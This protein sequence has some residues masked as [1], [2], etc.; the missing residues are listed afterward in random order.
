MTPP[1][2]G[3]RSAGG[4]TPDGLTPAGLWSRTFVVLCLLGFCSG[5]ATAPYQSL[6]PVYVEADLGRLPLFTA[7]LRSLTLILGGIFAIVGGRLADV[8]GLKTTLLL[9]LAGAGLTGL[10][11]HAHHIVPLTMLILVI[12]AAAGPWSTAGQSYLIASAGPSRLGLGGA[13]YFLSGTAGNSVGSLCTGFV[14]D[15][16][17]FP[18]LGTVMA[19]I[20]GG[21]FVLGL[22]LLPSTRVPRAVD[23]RRERLALWR[24][25]RPLLSH[26]NVHLLLGIRLTITSF[27]GMATLVLPLLVY[28]A[29]QSASTA[30]Y[31]GAVSLAVAAA[32]QLLTGLLRDRLG[33]TGPLIVSSL[34]IVVSSACLALYVDSIPGLFVFGTLLTA[35]AWAVSTLIP[36][37]IA[38]VAIEGEKNRLIGLGHMVWSASM[39]TG[40]I[41]GGILVEIGPHLPFVLG[42]VHALGGTLCIWRLCRR[43]DAGP[44]NR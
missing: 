43:L 9:G 35:T 41:V 37:L 23:T 12:G 26:R 22:L 31:Y 3:G 28:R 42:V 39:V 6:L 5:F 21:V 11:F 18:Q 14:K 10:V 33:R 16:W 36:A 17:S 25:Y 38:E 7:Y 27:W 20:M 4:P 40:S 44:G 32:G 19:C 34:G 15:N 24:S 1:P 8:L 30:A 13:L 2:S 29:S